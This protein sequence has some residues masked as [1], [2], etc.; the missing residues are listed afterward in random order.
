MRDIRRWSYSADEIDDGHD[1]PEVDEDFPIT[2]MIIN[3]QRIIIQSIIIQGII[4]ILV[5]SRVK[6]TDNCE[7]RRKRRNITTLK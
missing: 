6:L 2:I 1:L 4:L 7:R 3:M 5:T